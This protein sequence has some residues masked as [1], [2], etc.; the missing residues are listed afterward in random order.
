MDPEEVQAELLE[1]LEDWLAFESAH[2]E[3]QILQADES[4]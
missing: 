3:A 2:L 4:V 1:Q